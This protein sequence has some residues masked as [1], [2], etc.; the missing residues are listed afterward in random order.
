MPDRIVPTPS[1]YAIGIDLGTTN[2]VLAYAALEGVEEG[3]ESAVQLLPIPQVV[4]PSTVEARNALPSFLYLGTEEEGAAGVLDL[5]TAKGREFAVGEM[6]RRRSAEVAARTVVAAKSWLAHHRVDRHQPNLPWNA[7]DNLPRV[8]PVEATRRY[9]EHLVGAWHEAFPE[10]PFAAQ[11]VVLTVPA[12]FDASARE[13]THEAALAAGFA[14]DFILLEE[15]QAAVYAWLGD[16]GEE[17]RRELGP[18]DVLLVCDVGGGTTDLSLIR[19]TEE[20]GELLLERVA[21]GNH[22]LVGGDNMDLALAH[23]VA[24]EFAAQGT[25]V[26][27]WQSVALWHACRA[28]KEAVLTEGGP[29]TV[30]VAIQGRGSRLIGGTVSVDLDQETARRILLDGFFPRCAVTEAP[31]GRR[32]SGFQELGLPFEA[33]PAVTRHLAHFLSAHAADGEAFVQ[34]THVLFNGG[35][36]KSEALQQRLVDVLGGWLPDGD[37]VARLHR[38]EDLDFAVAR[39]AAYYG[40]AKAGRGVRIHGG[41]PRSYYVGIETSGLAIPGMPRPLKAL[42]VVPFGMEEG[43]EVE[44][45]GHPVG[46]VVGEPASF[47]FFSSTGRPDDTAG[48]VIE[49][50]R[51]GDL[52][53]TDALETEL[54]ADESLDDGFVT[55]E[56]RS[57]LSELGMF[58]LWCVRTTGDGRWK[59][60]F[61]V[62]DES[63]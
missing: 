19:V 55:V 5:S 4:A 8:S 31:G 61:S 23:H 47:R 51:D 39:G 6:A 10:H 54:P 59:L 52:V 53:E 38:H 43:T 9:L 48:T 37:A 20:A 14:A 44:V 41:A 12:S 2:S 25:T 17:W 26:D 15:P 40:I 30:P 63:A 21:V 28:A 29:E 3:T 56:F 34:P 60:E 24:A 18:G 42:C 27:A 46:L 45:P 33:D 36:L 11:Q 16:Q 35:C 62:R 1:R 13:L 49:S 57:R 7:P 58:E 50:W 32:S 22:I